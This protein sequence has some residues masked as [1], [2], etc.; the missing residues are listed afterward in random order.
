ML[1]VLRLWGTK[2][3]WFLSREAEGNV[4]HIFL[5]R[6]AEG[7]VTGIFWFKLAEGSIKIFCVVRLRRTK[8]TCFLSSEVEGNV[9]HSV[10][11]DNAEGNETYIFLV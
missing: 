4:A 8:Q 6:Q 11:A 10:K 9:A 7:N 2:Q 5:G 1:C 3:V